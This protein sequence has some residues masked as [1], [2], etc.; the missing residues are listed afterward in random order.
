MIPYDLWRNFNFLSFNTDHRFPPFLLYVNLGANLGKL[1]Y[2]DVSVMINMVSEGLL[3]TWTCYH[4][5]HSKI[6]LGKV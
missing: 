2:G 4:D 1:L 5:M 3:F 6:V